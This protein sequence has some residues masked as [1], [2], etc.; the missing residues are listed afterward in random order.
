MIKQPESFRI[1]ALQVHPES[2]EHYSSVE[3]VLSLALDHLKIGER[4]EMFSY[5]SELLAT[6]ISSLAL[7]Q[8][9]FD[10]PSDFMLNENS[11]AFFVL[12]LQVI[13]DYHK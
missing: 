13:R 5:I 2:M 6:D 10:S 7:Q 11:R 4:E 12:I 8:I 3:K 1:F 9:W